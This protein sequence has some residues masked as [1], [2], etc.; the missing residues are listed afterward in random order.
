[1]ARRTVPADHPPFAA[2]PV[3]L[4]TVGGPDERIAVHVAGVMAPGRTPLVCLAGYTRNIV[5]F[6]DFLP[7]LQAEAGADWPVLLIDLRGRGRSADRARA[8][9]YSTLADARDVSEIARAFAI[10]R[11]VFLGQGH[12]GQVLMA[13]AAQRPTLIAGTV[14]IDSGPALAP[15]SLIRLRSNA[16]AIG[17]LRGAGGLTVMLRR[18]LAADY[19][20]RAPEALDRLAARFQHVDPKGR[21]VP[22]Y[23]PA[24]IERLRD[25]G[26]DDVLEPQW[27]LFDLLGVAP[28][29]IARTAL[30][31][32]LSSELLEEMR[33]RRPD[34][35][36]LAIAGQ[37]SPAL[38]DRREDVA[39]IAQFLLR[40]A[41][42]G[43]RPARRA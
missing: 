24:L 6:A 21:A 8:R 29:L 11:A 40:A 42:A 37:G 14:L 33:Q 27:G 26:V 31:D 12:G 39:P 16:Q 5:D 41:E 2:L 9:D 28:M 17:N 15:R 30:T 38:L 7:L 3:R 19:P 1:M 4:V 43:E 34:A 13:L 23:D 18:M 25:F 32:Q 22:L 20:D 35:E 36:L 10:E